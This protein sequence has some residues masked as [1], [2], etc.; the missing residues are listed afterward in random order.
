MTQLASLHG[1]DDLYLGVLGHRR[2]R[3]A[4]A[5]DDG[6]VEGHGDTELVP[7]SLV[8]IGG[9]TIRD[10]TVLGVAW[11]GAAMRALAEEVRTAAYEIIA[12]KGWTNWAIGSMMKEP[13]SKRR[14]SG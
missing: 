6:R 13:P 8:S 5:R 3:P 9:T 14:I 4:A 7:W 11:D 2:G 1:G 10:R 12:R